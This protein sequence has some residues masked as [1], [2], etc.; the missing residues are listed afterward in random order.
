MQSVHTHKTCLRSIVSAKAREMCG[1]GWE[2]YPSASLVIAS[3]DDLLLLHGQG[4][5]LQVWLLTFEDAG[6]K[7]VLIEHM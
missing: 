6:V 1:K 3:H 7:A 5:C 2:W 4:E